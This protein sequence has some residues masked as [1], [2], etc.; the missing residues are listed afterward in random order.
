MKHLQ[1]FEQE[2]QCLVSQDYFSDNEEMLAKLAAGAK[3]YDLIVPTGNAMETLIRQNALRPINL[4]L[5]P[6]FKNIDPAYLGTVFD[7]GNKFQEINIWCP[8]LIRSL[9][10]VLIRAN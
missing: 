1:R 5:L 3:G 4:S 9:C 6:Y 8:M 10:L 2:C 7:P